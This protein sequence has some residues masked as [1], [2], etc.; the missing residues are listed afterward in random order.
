[1]SI[2]HLGL[3]GTALILLGLA[4][5]FGPAQGQPPGGEKEKQPGPQ[6]M[7]KD[8]LERLGTV[9]WRH[10]SRILCLAYSPNGRILAAGG[11]DD[12]IRLWDTDTGLELRNCPEPWVNAIGWSPRGSVLVTGGAFKTIRLWAAANGKELTQIKGHNAAIKSLAVSPDGQM[13]ASGGQDG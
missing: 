12:P 8:A 9:Q 4:T 5:A 10:G 2:K 3:V 6:A 11:G 7:P 1:M 13:I